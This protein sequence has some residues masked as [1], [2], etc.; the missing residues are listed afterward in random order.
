MA[1]RWGSGY[2]SIYTVADSIRSDFEPGHLTGATKTGIL[3]TAFYANPRDPVG[4]KNTAA[5]KNKPV[6]TW[7]QTA[8]GRIIITVNTKKTGS[9]AV[10][11]IFD[12]HGW[13][14]RRFNL[15]RTDSGVS[16]LTWNSRNNNGAKTAHALV[17]LRYKDSMSTSAVKVL[18]K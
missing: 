18:V 9:D 8:T 10:L 15:A 16:T 11:E 5:Q 17:L 7:K 14:L 2:G 13:L 3:V 12:L 4:I 6:I 1:H